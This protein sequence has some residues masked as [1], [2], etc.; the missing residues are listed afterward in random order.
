MENRK[1][2]VV[3]WWWQHTLLIPT[4]GRQR[5]PHFLE[6]KTSMVYRASSRIARATQRSPG[7]KNP[8]QQSTTKSVA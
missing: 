6:I 7:L 4:L 2:K 5:P 3:G 8:K 1:S